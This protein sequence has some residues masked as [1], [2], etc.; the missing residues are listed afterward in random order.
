MTDWLNAKAADLGRAVA[1]GTLD[2]VEL[3]DA[4]LAAIE[5]HPKGPDIYARPMPE[6]AHEAALAARSR[7]KEG[8]L[9]GPLDGVPVSWKDLFDTAGVVTE[10]GSRILAGRIPKADAVVVERGTAAGLVPLGKTHLSELAF[11]GLGINPMTA[12]APNP[13]GEGLCPG[14]SSS[15]AA[16]SLSFGLAAGAIGS[17]TGGSVRIPAAWH[18]LV[19][20]KSTH[21]LVPLDGAVPLIPSLDTVGPLCRSVEDAALLHAILA[22]EAPADLSGASLSGTRLLV[23]TGVFAENLDRGIARA[24]EEAVARLAA[25]GARI[26]ER[27]LV[28]PRE[29]LTHAWTVG[30]ESYAVWGEAIE[31]NPDAM[32]PMIRARFETGKGHDA[33]RYQRALLA[34][35]RLRGDWLAET[36]DFDAVLAPTTAIPAP[37]I[38]PLL[39]DDQRYIATNMLALRNTRIGNMLGLSAL[40]LPTGTPMAGLMLIGRPMGEAALLR[41]GAA[42]ERALG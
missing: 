4:F 15:G 13:H 19:G 21:G 11:S 22:D 27:T 7:A 41:L 32:F 23:D 26:E 14:G 16:A 33:V 35:A 39:A 6:A 36:Q 8:R 42:A 5:A 25:A 38:A 2:P 28:S 3:T 37:E 18:D 20:L 31:A 9:R 24:F 29:V 10:A 30:V 17:D 34:I 1:G 40:T 12:T